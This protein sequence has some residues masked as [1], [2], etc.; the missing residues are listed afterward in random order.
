MLKRLM[1]TKEAGGQ[2]AIVIVKDDWRTTD[3]REGQYP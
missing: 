2:R 3:V 1:V